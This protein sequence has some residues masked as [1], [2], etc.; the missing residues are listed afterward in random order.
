MKKIIIVNN[1][2]NLGGV[3]KA[4]LDLLQEISGRYE[5]TLFLFSPTGEYMK[6]IPS[7]VNI[8][9]SSSLFRC[10]GLGQNECKHNPILYFIRGFLA[11]LTKICGRRIPMQIIL[12]SQ[13]KLSEHYDCAISYLQNGGYKSFYGGCNEFVLNKINADRKIT[14]LHG[15]YGRCGANYPYNNNLYRRF[16]IVAA[17]SEGCR[18]SFLRYLPDMSDNIVTVINCHNYEKIKQL[19]EESPVEYD[20][21]VTNIVSVARLSLEKGIDRGLRAIAEAIHAGCRVHYHVIGDG[22]QRAS[23]ESL[24]NELG[25]QDSVNF[26]GSTHNPY[27]YMKNADLLLIPSYHEAAP[28]VI[29]EALCLGLPVL[30]TETTS[31]KDMILDR[32]IGWVCKNS[33]ENLTITLIDIIK[34]PKKLFEYR[35]NLSVRKCSNFAAVESFMGLLE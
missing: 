5:I 2:M 4:L 21:G 15:D 13:G 23:L 28:L 35:T 31:S 17:C 6:D 3:S 19:A 25:I 24:A 33:Q 12:R 10:L 20:R 11:A 29:D 27:R 32:D 26:Y 8:I 22:I 7:S 30:S 9:S 18:Q 16:N 1:N 14:F 34:A